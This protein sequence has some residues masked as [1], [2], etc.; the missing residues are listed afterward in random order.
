VTTLWGESEIIEQVMQAS[1]RAIRPVCEAC[2]IKPGGYSQGLRAAA[3]DFGAENSFE[4]AAQRLRLHHGVTLSPSTLREMTLQAGAAAQKLNTR[5]NPAAALPAR[6]ADCVEVQTDG[7]MLPMLGFKPGQGDRRKLRQCHW[8][9]QRLCVARAH[10][11]ATARYACNRGDLVQ[12]GRD[13]SHC[14]AQAGRGLNTRIHAVADGA[15][16]IARKVPETFG[17]ETR[18]LV[19]YCHASDYLAAVAKLH[20]ALAPRPGWLRTQQRRLKKGR[21]RE[22][23]RT[24]AR[25]IERPGQPDEL[26]PARNAH[27]YL[28]N[29]TGQLWYDEAIEA[30]LPIG[31]G[32]VEAS[33]RHV[34]QARLKGSGVWWLPENA[35]KLSHLR[36]LRANGQFDELFPLAA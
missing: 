11:S 28:A 9:E 30:G 5:Q 17:P 13:W 16:W 22:V 26:S 10:G 4:K 36:V 31:S 20:P 1:G 3:V 18:L 29:R 15:E 2:E 21:Y 12:L 34:L 25:L 35:D 19:D 24:L 23:I 33:H 32:L 14:A 7:T 8:E 27:R 6:G